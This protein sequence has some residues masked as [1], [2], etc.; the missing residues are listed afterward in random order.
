MTA[1]KGE[2]MHGL[3]AL[4]TI[5]VCAV[6]AGCGVTVADLPLPAP[7][8]DTATYTIHAEFEN[9]LNL[10]DQAKVK[11]GGAEIG[12]V[13]GIRVREF[14]AVVDLEIRADIVLPPGSTAELRQA[15]PLGD[16][17]V[18]VSRPAGGTGRL[19]DGDT[20]PRERTSAGATVEEVLLS[21]SMLFHGGGVSGLGT[22]GAELAAIVDGRGGDL[23]HLIT[24]MSGVVRELNAN[25][26]RVDAVLAE[27]GSL[28]ATLDGR[29][30]ELALVADSL[31]GALGA[32]AANNRAITDLLAR[33]S[34]TTTALGDYSA[35]TGDQLAALLADLHE[36]MGALAATGDDFGY[37][38]DQLRTIRPFLDVS[39]QGK[40]LGAYMTL[41]SLELGVLTDPAS[42]RLH[43][44]DEVTDFVGSF[45]QVLQIVQGRIQGP[46]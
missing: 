36:L 37:T 20:L 28:T 13:A 26:A 12:V 42:S 15:T 35:S 3:R 29:R 23:A 6:T 24:E 8:S 41:T 40:S 30:G 10:P 33:I 27:F 21:L 2:I 39:G 5:A 9:A 34:T 31:P 22:L 46:R 1:R 19:A 7:G 43:G 45:L 14:Q 4:F 17:F 32:V 16:V 44:P 18:A 38:L 25:S 11:I